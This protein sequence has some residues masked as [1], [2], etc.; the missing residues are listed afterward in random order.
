MRFLS[1]RGQSQP[2]GLQQALESGLAPDGGLY[3]PEVLPQFSPNDFAGCAS[4]AAVAHRLLTPFF[5]QA[6][7]A[8]GARDFEITLPPLGPGG[9]SAHLRLGSGPS[10]RQDFACERGGEEWADPRP[11][12]VRLTRIADATEGRAVTA[13]E[14]AD[15]RFP[16]ATEIASERQTA[17]VLPPWAWTLAA[18]VA[19]GAHWVTRRKSGLF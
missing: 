9:Y 2:A 4:P 7:I 12:P 5:E 16:K 1:T 3:V 17:P 18:S 15:L 19:L 11:D 10:T 13:R 14:A 6:P 8:A